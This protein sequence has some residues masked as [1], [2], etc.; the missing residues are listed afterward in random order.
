MPYFWQ[1]NAAWVPLPA[2]GAPNRI[3]LMKVLREQCRMVGLDMR[4]APTQSN[5]DSMAC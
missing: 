3:N 5:E 1:M 4:H 2:P